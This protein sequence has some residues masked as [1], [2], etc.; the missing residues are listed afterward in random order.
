[1][2]GQED[3]VFMRLSQ[4]AFWNQAYQEHLNHFKS[5]YNIA[6]ARWEM[7]KTHPKTKLI[8]KIYKQGNDFIDLASTLLQFKFIAVYD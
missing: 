6:C 4:A 5:L 8:S 2:Q 7:M 1:M 3:P